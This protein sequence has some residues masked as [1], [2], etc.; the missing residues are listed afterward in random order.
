VNQDQY[1]AAY[2]QIE[3]AAKAGRMSWESACARIALLSLEYGRE[4]ERLWWAG[5]SEPSGSSGTS[6]PPASPSS[7]S[8]TARP[9]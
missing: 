2:E 3:A 5:Q 8:A 7:S 4:Q 6:E 1:R 9:G